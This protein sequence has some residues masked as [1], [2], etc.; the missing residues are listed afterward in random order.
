[1]IHWTNA[2]FKIYY[3]QRYKIMQRYMQYPHQVQREVLSELLKSARY[4]EFGK[5]Y[6]FKDIKTPKQ[7]AERVPVQD[8]EAF[9]PLIRRMM[10]GEKDILWDGRVRYFAKSSG[11]TSAKSKFIPLSRQSLKRCHI[12][13][14]W[15]AMTLMYHNRPDAKIFGS[16]NMVMGGSISKFAPHPNTEFGDVSGFMIRSIP[17]VARPFF[18]PDFETALMAEWE[19]KLEKLALAAVNTPGVTMI[20][21]VPTWTVV[22]FRRMLEISGKSNILEV[23]PNFQAYMHGGVS[24]TPYREQFKAFLPSEEVSYQ[25]IY[26]ASEG[27]F[28]AQ[29][30]FDEEGL[31]LFLNNGIYFEFI[32]ME[33]WGQEYPKAI[34]LAEVETGKH[35]ALVITTNGGLWRYLLGDT[36][37]FV[38]TA[39]YRIK[40][41]GRTKQYVN[42]FGEEVVVENTDKALAYACEKTGAQVEDYTVAPIYFGQGDRGGHE[43]LVEFE[44]QPEDLEKFR[45]LLDRQLQRLNS[46]YEAKRYKDIALKKLVIKS[47]PSGSFHDWLRSKGK[48]GGQHKVPRLANNRQYVDE[49]LEFLGENV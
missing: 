8:Y 3:Q 7:F 5:T 39:P 32:P 38:A 10:H 2:A 34:P 41:T 9:K 4:T 28:A 29:Y 40:V 46:D 35:Y 15:D 14:S 45:D 13:G 17:H 47:L 48:Y 12:R 27:N 6:G 36:I 44:K 42:A 21:G 16:K 30:D 37:S 1:M 49:I 43:W 31:L 22:L 33:E 19:E 23:W 26:N 11:T 24:F 25:E 18:T 20:G